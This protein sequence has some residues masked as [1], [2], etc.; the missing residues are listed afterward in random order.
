[1][2][3]SKKLNIRKLTVFILAA[4]MLFFTREPNPYMLAVGVLLASIGEFFRIWGAGHLTKNLELTTSGPYAHLRHPLYV[5]TGLVMFGLLLPA[6]IP[7]DWVPNFSAPNFYILIVAFLGYAFYYFPYKNQNE[8]ERMIRRFGEDAEHWVANVPQFIPRPTRY[9]R[10]KDKKW[11]WKQTVHN[12]EAGVPFAI[13][14]GFVI[15]ARSWWL[16]PLWENAPKWLFGDF[17]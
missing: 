2:P 11:S 8:A 15:I 17:S 16:S 4:A 5:G 3:A 1:M 10:A 12:S 7:P 13:L 14:A 9:E 6:T